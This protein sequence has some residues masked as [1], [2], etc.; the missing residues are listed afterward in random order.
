MISTPL[1]VG[2]NIDA[3]NKLAQPLRDMLA[4]AEVG[5]KAFANNAYAA[6]AGRGAYAAG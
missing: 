6:F 5:A 2:S 1:L 4:D 3:N